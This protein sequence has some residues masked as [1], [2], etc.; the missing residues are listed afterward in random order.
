MKNF[1]IALFFLASCAPSN[2]QELRYEGEGEIKK[3]I[4][5]LKKIETKEDVQRSYK[6][7]KKHFGRIADLIILCEEASFLRRVSPTAEQRDEDE[8]PSGDALFAE[9]ARVYEIPGA[10]AIV[11]AAQ[12]EAVRRLDRFIHKQPKQSGP[13][14]AGN[15]NL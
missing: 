3:F 14:F 10:K 4:S 1:F 12:E 9:L 15:P 13:D 2:L 5:D 7:L 6:R 11:E 8:T